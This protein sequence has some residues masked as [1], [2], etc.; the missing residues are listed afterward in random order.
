M[1]NFQLSRSSILQG[2]LSRRALLRGAGACLALPA[3]EAMLPRRAQAAAPKPLRF[4]VWTLPDGVRMDAWTPKETGAAYTITPILKPLEAHRARFNLISG[5]ANTPASVVSGDVF[6]GSHARATGAMLTQMPLTF[7]SGTNIK[8]GISVDQLIANQLKQ[9]VPGLRL[10]SLE[11][12]AVYAGATGNC[13]DGFS[14]AYLT[15]L[16][17]SGPTTFLPKETN[18]KAVFDRLTK[19]GL[20]MA[21][22]TPSPVQPGAAA[23]APDKASVYQKS[24]LDLVVADTNELKLHLG[25]SDRDKLSDYLDSV[26]ELERRIQAVMPGVAAM[27][28]N[29]P[30]AAGG[31]CQSIPMPID[32]TYLGSERAKN[33][34]KYPDLLKVMND[35]MA[36]AVSCDLTRV[37]TFMSEI[38]LNTQT[39]FAFLGVDSSNYHDEISHHGG[40]ATKLAGMQ[41]VNTFYAEQFAYF[42]TKLA[43]QTDVDGSSLLD[44]CIIMFTS[45]FGDGDNHYHYDLPVLLAG[46]AGGLFKTG[47]HIAYPS[48]ADRG[49]GAVETAR[50]GD[51]PLANL[52][53]SI[54]QAFGMNVSTF[55]S[56]DGTTPYGTKPLSELTTG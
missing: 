11:L 32:G 12:G 38:P 19:G 23:P 47:R 7:T 34:Y 25:K 20:P 4:I 46:G 45:E 52:Y 40:N 1:R 48:V 49:A 26:N 37:I 30:A 33:V 18:P 6:A 15:N 42:L 50:R 10:P 2:T 22:S 9:S 41:K 54:M 16:A 39:N 56:I 44:N 35:L 8:N 53:I 14:C 43:G 27:G 24:I 13:E 31:S 28:M 21:G 55:G 17:W 51:M 3:L 29:A 36:F 5:L